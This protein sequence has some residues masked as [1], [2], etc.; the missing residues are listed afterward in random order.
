VALYAIFG[1]IPT[2]WE[3]VDTQGSVMDNIHSQLLTPGNLMQAEPR[4]LLQDFV[5]DPHNYIAILRAIAADA[6]TQKEISSH[7]GLAQG[8]VSK[9]TS[10]LREAGFVERRTPV[11]SGKRSR[12]GRYHIKDP[13][14]RFYYRFLST[15]QAQLALNIKEPAQAEIERHLPR[16]IGT[17][18]WEEISREW[19]LR[20]SAAGNL[21]FLVDQVGSSWTRDVQL[22]V[23]GVNQGEKR[24]ILGECKWHAREAGRNV[25]QELVGKTEGIL[26]DQGHW[27][28]LYLG[29]SRSGWTESAQ[30]YA[31]GLGEGTKGSGNWSIEGMRLLDLEQVDEDMKETFYSEYTNAQ[32]G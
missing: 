9:Y 2:Y 26:P 22:D 24:I 14:L 6:R 17:H 15:R 7:T 1:G 28:V 5:R 16:F 25:L 20:S 12:L 32:V 29:F 10:V 3:R 21:P 23:V 31:D 13:Y 27:R 8:H 11:L 30:V 19:V 18:T 4:L